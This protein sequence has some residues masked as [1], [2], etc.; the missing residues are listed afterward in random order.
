MAVNGRG[1]WEPPPA[2]RP[3]LPVLRAP[4]TGSLLVV[5]LSDRPTVCYTHWA[6]ASGL[7]PRGRE[8]RCTAERCACPLCQ[9][10]RALRWTGWIGAL[11]WPSRRLCAV[12]ITAGAWRAWHARPPVA[13]PVRQIGRAHV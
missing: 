7:F 2:A 12:A 8:V 13:M 5:C 6:D 9:A 3:Y 1:G 10:G 11:A 4:A